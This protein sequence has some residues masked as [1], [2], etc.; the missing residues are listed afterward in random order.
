MTAVLL[1]C[2]HLHTIDLRGAY[3]YTDDAIVKVIA[4]QAHQLTSLLLG[5][6]QQVTRRGLAYLTAVRCPMLE[7]CHLLLRLHDPSIILCCHFCFEMMH[8][9]VLARP[10]IG[11]Q[12]SNCL[13]GQW[14]QEPVQEPVQPGQQ[15]H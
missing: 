14:M 7:V 12:G 4:K 13:A 1:R 11:L 5:G 10:M 2:Q 3:A 9:D 8:R 15:E 6:C